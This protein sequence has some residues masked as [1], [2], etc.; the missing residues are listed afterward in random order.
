[1]VGSHVG[2][3]NTLAAGRGQPHLA[4]ARQIPYGITPGDQVEAG[5]VPN[6][7]LDEVVHDA[8]VGV[9]EIGAK[10]R[11]DTRQLEIEVDHQNRLALAGQTTGQDK[12]GGGAPDTAFVAVHGYPGADRFPVDP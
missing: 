2:A 7:R 11:T 8:M 9:S 3:G 10:Q 4:V 6:C 12:G 1:M 5:L